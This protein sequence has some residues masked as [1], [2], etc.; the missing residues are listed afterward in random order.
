VALIAGV[1]T[2]TQATKVEIRDADSGALVAQGRAPHPSVTPPVS[3][4]HPHDWWDAFTEAWS[5]AGS[6]D[7]AAISVAA[8]QHGCVVLDAH[9]EPLRPAKLWNDVTSAPDAAWLVD[10]LPAGAAGWAQAAGS[11]PVAA[12]TIAKLSWLHR[13]EPDAWARIAHVCLPHDWMTMRLTGRLVTDRGDASGTGYWSPAED[14]YRF[15]LLAIVDRDRDWSHVLPEVLGPVDAGGEWN[16]AVVGPGTGDNMAAALGLGLE[17]GD[18]AVSIGTSGTVFAVSDT[19]TADPRGAVAGF[20]D[21]TG[22]YLPLVCTLN[23]TRVTDA[24][25]RVVGRT[26]DELDRLA[27][28]AEPGAGGLVLLPY[29]DGERTP[30]RPDATG[31]LAGI[32]SDVSAAQLARAAYEGVVCGLLDGLDALGAHARVD[33]GALWLV[34]GGSRSSTYRQVLADLAQRPVTTRDDVETVALG[35]AVQAAATL[36]GEEPAEI[37]RRWAEA[38]SFGPTVTIEPRLEPD[39][40]ATIRQRYA[41]RRELEA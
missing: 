29:L 22:R 1:D 13:S 35:A 12:F 37:H 2:S 25:A 26:V 41:A 8:Q 39:L 34:G 15:D 20:A 28:D 4:Q 6:P 18:V 38:G 30:D 24:V 31:T 14:R 17:P 23:A 3:E 33:D 19:P 5:A 7:V 36:A 21:A 32:R 16:G 11:V 10:Q 27:V 40:A 9:R